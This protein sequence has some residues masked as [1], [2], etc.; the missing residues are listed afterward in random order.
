[1]AALADEAGTRLQGGAKFPTG[2]KSR[3]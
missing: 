1:M 3:K 2:G